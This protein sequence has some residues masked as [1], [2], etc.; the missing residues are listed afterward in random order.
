MMTG[1]KPDKI[2]EEDIIAEEIEEEDSAEEILEIETMI[3]QEEDSEE[4]MGAAEAEDLEE[5]KLVSYYLINFS[6]NLFRI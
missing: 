6:F 1:E 4:A 5:D 2:I 3:I